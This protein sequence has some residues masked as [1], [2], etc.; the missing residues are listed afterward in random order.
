MKTQEKIIE[1]LADLE[2]Q[3]WAKK[4]I[5]IKDGQKDDSKLLKCSKCQRETSM[6]FC[7]DCVSL[8]R[9]EGTEEI[10]KLLNSLI[11]M[12]QKS[13]GNA[14]KVSDIILNLKKL[15]QKFTALPEGEK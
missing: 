10:L 15:H 7:V 11:K 6:K 3:Q 14:Q 12:Y 13:N 1:K 5:A 4:A 2:H 8:E 9:N